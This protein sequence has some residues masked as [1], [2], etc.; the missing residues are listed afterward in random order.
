MK[1]FSNDKSHR[2]EFSVILIFSLVNDT[3]G[4]V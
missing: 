2:I 4:W 3:H 1:G